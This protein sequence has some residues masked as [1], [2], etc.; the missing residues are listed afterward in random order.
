MR[1]L[2][3]G[4][5]LALVGCGP[6]PTSTGGSGRGGAPSVGG[7]GGLGGTSGSGGTSGVG[8]TGNPGINQPVIPQTAGACPEFR[9]GAQTIMTLSTQIVAGTPGP[10]KGPLLFTWHGTGGSGQ[11]ALRQLPQSVQQDIIRQ[12]GIVIAASSNGQVRSGGNVALNVWF[13][14]HDLEYADLITSC[15]IRNHNIDPRRVY[16]TGCS[17]GGLMAGVMSMLRSTYVAAAAPNSGGLTTSARRLQ[18][19][20]RAPAVMTLHGG[21]NDT[22]FINFQTTSRNMHTALRGSGAFMV[23]CNHASGHCGAPAA[24]HERAWQFMQAHPFGTRPSPYEAGLP[25]GF[26]SYC[27]IVR[28]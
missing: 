23:D 3:L 28:Q 13:D 5:V 10:I 25:A 19:P 8:G 1:I 22:V 9:T 18:D 17:A 21:A 4:I 14:G 27:T 16:V 7:T 6:R 2:L 15:A 24:L 20:S 26:P 11:Q 12:G